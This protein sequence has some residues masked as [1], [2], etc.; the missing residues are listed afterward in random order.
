ML[1]SSFPLTICLQLAQGLAECSVSDA[2]KEHFLSM[3]A[4]VG[5]LRAGLFLQGLLP[6]LTQQDRD[7]GRRG[8]PVSAEEAA[9][10]DPSAEAQVCAC[11]CSALAQLASSEQ[12]LPLLLGHPVLA[13][14]DKLVSSS[15]PE[16][17][18]MQ[19]A[20]I[21]AKAALLAVDLHETKQADR[22]AATARDGGVDNGPTHIMLSYAWAVQSMIRRIRDALDRRGYRVW[23][24]VERMQGSTLDA[25]SGA[26]DNAAVPPLPH[27][28]CASL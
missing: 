4:S 22:V 16:S 6:D 13:D 14:L 2:H 3:P 12:T 10:G 7:D 21:D 25:M 15:L 24:D 9:R 26:V 28:Y 5:I 23:L 8:A 11:C 17:T 1:T 19:D 27:R 20:L 18:A